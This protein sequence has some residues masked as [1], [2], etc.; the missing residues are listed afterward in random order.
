MKTLRL[1]FI[2]IILYSCQNQAGDTRAA[3]TPPKLKSDT[4]VDLSTGEFP[5]VK[6]DSLLYSFFKNPLAVD[7]FIYPQIGVICI[8][9]GPGV[10]ALI[11]QGRSAED[12]MAY[13]DFLFLCR[14]ISFI[15]PNSLLNPQGFD[16]CN[17]QR[18]GYVI[19]DLAAGNN[20]FH[21]LYA[22]LCESNALEVNAALSKDLHW[23]DAQSQQ[24]VLITWLDKQGDLQQLTLHF[25]RKQNTL[26]LAAVDLRECGV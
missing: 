7:S 10:Q 9:P 18:E 19:L 13:D 15:K 20:H 24:K 3:S 23:L 17:W 4:L 21:D 16:P 14:D 1:F 8:E 22:E 11:K 2:L 26:F 12:L 6:T 5:L 25:F